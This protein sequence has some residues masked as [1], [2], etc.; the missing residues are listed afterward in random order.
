METNQIGSKNITAWAFKHLF[1]KTWQKGLNILVNVPFVR[2]FL[3]ACQ[4]TRSPFGCIRADDGTVN[5]SETSGTS[6]IPAGIKP[7][8]TGGTEEHSQYS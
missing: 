3:A 8:L 6:G 2:L 5:A 4:V 7:W 1:S